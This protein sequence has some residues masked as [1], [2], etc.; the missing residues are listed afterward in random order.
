MRDGE[1]GV[2]DCCET[3]MG[4][5]IEHVE[6]VD[7]ATGVLAGFGGRRSCEFVE[8]LL[9]GPEAREG[10]LGTSR[11]EYFL[12][13]ALVHHTPSDVLAVMGKRL[14]IDA[15]G[16]VAEGASNG[17][18]AM[19]YRKVY[20][21]WCMVYEG[22]LA[23]GGIGELGEVSD[24]VFLLQSA[25]QQA[26]GRHTQTLVNFLTVTQG[27]LPPLGTDRSQRLLQ[28]KV[29]YALVDVDHFLSSNW[30]WRDLW[31]VKMMAASIK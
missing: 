6:D 9:H 25:L 29:P 22:G 24:A 27:L 31:S 2:N 10:Y 12:Q 30:M 14:H 21:V 23:V 28:I 19:T 16:A 5:L 17:L 11:S 3:A 15:D 1:L 26:I 7:V 13:F 20:S 4:G 8:T 18:V